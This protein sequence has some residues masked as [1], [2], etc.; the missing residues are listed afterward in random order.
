MLVNLISVSL[1]EVWIHVLVLQI[2]KTGNFQLSK[3]M[4]QVLWF[5]AALELFCVWNLFRTKLKWIGKKLFAH[6]D[7]MFAN[8]FPWVLKP[9]S[10]RDLLRN[11]VGS[12]VGE[13]GALANEFRGWCFWVAAYLPCVPSEPHQGIPVLLF[14]RAGAMVCSYISHLN[15]VCSFSWPFGMKR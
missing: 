11:P 14:P 13:H 7:Q 2:K 3:L 6:P 10:W 5:W 8:H 1:L 12:I 15:A 9:F 4:Q